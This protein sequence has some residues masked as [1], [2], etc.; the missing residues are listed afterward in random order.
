M[1]LGGWHMAEIEAAP[2][3]TGVTDPLALAGIVIG[4]VE[5]YSSVSPVRTVLF[6]SMAVANR[7]CVLFWLTTTGLVVV[8][9]ALNVM[10]TGGQVEKKPAELAALATFA[11]I[12]TEP[13]WLAVATPFWSMV[14]T[15][16]FVPLAALNCK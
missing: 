10:D 14:T 8:P 13:G 1:Q 12:S 7:G 4:V 6:L 15:A 16:E 11:L 2:A 3:N 5:T 9:G